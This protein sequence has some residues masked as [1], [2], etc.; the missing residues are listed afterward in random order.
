VV[1]VLVGGILGAWIRETKGSSGRRSMDEIG[2]A[3]VRMVVNATRGEYS[4]GR[5]YR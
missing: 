5:K 1:F 4:E 3:L 2:H